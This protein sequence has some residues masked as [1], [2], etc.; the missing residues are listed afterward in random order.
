MI[1]CVHQDMGVYMKEPSVIQFFHALLYP[2]GHVS[3]M[4]GDYV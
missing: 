2:S 1:R 3:Y 4:E